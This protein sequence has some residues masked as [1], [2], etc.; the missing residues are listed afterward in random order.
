MNG[1]QCSHS[2]FVVRFSVLLLLILLR[3]WILWLILDDQDKIRPGTQTNTQNYNGPSRD[4]EA[5]QAKE[6]RKRNNVQPARGLNEPWEWYDKCYTR[7]RNKGEWCIAG[8]DN[9][10]L[11]L[12]LFCCHAAFMFNF[13][14]V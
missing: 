4:K 11:L 3:R 9:F 12:P 13:G 5:F 2:R 1:S 7:E 6:S 8:V 14:L 10:I